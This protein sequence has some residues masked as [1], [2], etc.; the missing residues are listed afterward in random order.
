MMRRNYES[1]D[2]DFASAV[3]ASAHAIHS[4]GEI[5]PDTKIARANTRKQD[6]QQ[7]GTN[8]SF[9]S[10]FNNFSY[11]LCYSLCISGV[12]ERFYEKGIYERYKEFTI[13][14]TCHW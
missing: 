3:A 14:Y 6:L 1:D 12:Y 13:C 2:S 5:T 4:L 9:N 8:I 7:R 10:L 11:Y